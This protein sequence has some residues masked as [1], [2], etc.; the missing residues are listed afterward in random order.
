[1][2]KG[3]SRA[4]IANRCAPSESKSNSKLLYDWRFTYRQSV[5]LQTPWDSQR[6]FF[7]FYNWTLDHSPHVTPSLTRRWVCLQWIRVWL[8][9]C[10]VC[11]SHVWHV[12]ENSSFCTIY[13]STVSTVLA[14]QIMSILRIL[15][16]N[17]SFV[18]WTVVSLTTAKF[19]PLIFSMSGFALS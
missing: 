5:R 4:Q 18:T 16:Y 10:Q 1:M 2:R 19:K 15:C 13:K 9:F 3:E 7:F 11:V 12:I 6:D 8:A 17:G 14:K